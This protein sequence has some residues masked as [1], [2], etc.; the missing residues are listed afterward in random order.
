MAFLARMVSFEMKT[1]DLKMSSHV[2][3][4]AS[5]RVSTHSRASTRVRKQPSHSF[6][7]QCSQPSHTDLTPQQDRMNGCTS[8]AIRDGTKPLFATLEVLLIECRAVFISRPMMQY[9][10]FSWW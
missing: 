1:L 4:H 9:N 5:S 2:S 3:S 7:T 6:L 10:H 8:Y